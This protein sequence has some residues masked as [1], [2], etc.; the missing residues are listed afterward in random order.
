L[1]ASF[2]FAGYTSSCFK[3]STIIFGICLH[4]K[5]FHKSILVDEDGWQVLREL[6]NF[7]SKKLPLESKLEVKLN[8]NTINFDYEKSSTEA[9]ASLFKY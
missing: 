7:L 1:P 3:L 2:A 4:S 9:F 8:R 6:W 5:Y